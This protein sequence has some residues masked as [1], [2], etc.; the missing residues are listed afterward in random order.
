MLVGI[1]EVDFKENRG[2]AIFGQKMTE[3]FPQS[4][5]DTNLHIRIPVNPK[6]DK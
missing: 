6:Q 5:K 4:V 2:E 3:N 1:P